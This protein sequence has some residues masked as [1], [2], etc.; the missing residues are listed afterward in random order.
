VLKSTERRVPDTEIG[1]TK[2]KGDKKIGVEIRRAVCPRYG[3]RGYQI[4]R[5]LKDRCKT[6]PQPD[7]PD[8]EIG[9]TK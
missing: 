7:A 2:Q 5:N 6:S 8:T 3:D 9:A 4:K 1:A